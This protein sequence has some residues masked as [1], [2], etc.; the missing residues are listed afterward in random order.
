VILYGCGWKTNNLSFCSSRTCASFCCSG[1]C[2]FRTNPFA[3]P[4]R[5]GYA[6]GF[7]VTCRLVSDTDA[8]RRIW[9]MTTRSKPDRGELLYQAPFP[10]AESMRESNEESSTS[11]EGNPSW[12]TV[13]VPFASFRYV[14][15]P[16]MIPDGPPLNT[17][18][19]LY[20]IGMTMSKFAFAERTTEIANFR[21]GFFELQIQDMGLYKRDERK[22]YGGIIQAITQPTVYTKRQAQW[23]RPV[24]LKMLS[25]LF[26][27]L[28]SEQRYVCW[29][30]IAFCRSVVM[31]YSCNMRRSLLRFSCH[32]V[33][34]S[35][36]ACCIFVLGLVVNGASRP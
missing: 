15:G 29:S 24:L 33:A 31:T 9:K 26:K 32:G 3:R 14:R 13:H 12:T 1:F 19:G 28:F 30:R 7:Y 6:D 23:R 5:V 18:G 27:L 4:L 10:L 22:V 2:G 17:T 11:G 21:D 16:R 8:D 34:Q 36:Y 20:Q 35:H 25:P